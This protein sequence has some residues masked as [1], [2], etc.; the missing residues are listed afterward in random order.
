MFETLYRLLLRTELPYYVMQTEGVMEL[1]KAALNS[2]KEGVVFWTLEFLRIVVLPFEEE[3]NEELER[4]NKA[5]LLGDAEFRDL[6]MKLLDTYAYKPTGTIVVL[7]LMEFLECVLSGYSNTTDPEV[8]EEFLEKLSQRHSILLSLFHSNCSGVTTSTALI[9]KTI[10]EESQ[11][12]VAQ[13][14][15]EAA[16]SEGVLLQHFYN[17]VYSTSEDQRYI[18]RYLV[19]LWM[20]EHEASRALLKRMVPIGIQRFLNKPALTDKEIEKYQQ[21][22]NARMEENSDLK[23]SR[24]TSRLR[25]RIQASKRDGND[26]GNFPLMFFM[27]LHDHSTYT[28][29]WNHETRNELKSALEKELNALKQAQDKV[30]EGEPKPLWNHEEFFIEYKSLKDEIVIDGFY[31]SKMVDQDSKVKLSIEKPSELFQAMYTRM[32]R[33]VDFANKMGEH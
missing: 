30:P 5:A 25:S 8:K 24:A 26:H 28:V 13:L 7:S 14:M 20:G 16:L 33:E 18:S 29:I 32:L 1:I 10:V 21:E 17:A 22:E 9:M 6:L 2:G 19:G 15:Q 12:E 11:N 4:A 31:I 27:M 3:R 23:P